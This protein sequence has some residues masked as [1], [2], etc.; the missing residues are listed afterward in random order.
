MTAALTNLRSGTTILIYYNTAFRFRWHR[1][2]KK[3]YVSKIFGAIFIIERLNLLV[4]T[5]QPQAVARKNQLYAEMGKAL[6][7]SKFHKHFA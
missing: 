3:F 5:E 4:S 6:K 2:Y 7:F 1:Q